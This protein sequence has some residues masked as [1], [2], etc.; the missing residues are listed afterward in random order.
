MTLPSPKLVQLAISSSS[1]YW[2]MLEQARPSLVYCNIP[3]LGRFFY[4][5]AC[6]VL[7][8][9]PPHPKAGPFCWGSCGDVEEAAMC[10]GGGVSNHVGFS[11]TS[12]W[13][14]VGVGEGVTSTPL[15]LFPMKL[16]LQLHI[17]IYIFVLGRLVSQK[18]LPDIFLTWAS[19]NGVWR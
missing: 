19:W 1:D 7:F 17:Y 11:D 16:C 9:L 2:L 13:G 14:G 8:G 12:E 15:R 3:L 6:S 4:P 5:P 18:N 10:C